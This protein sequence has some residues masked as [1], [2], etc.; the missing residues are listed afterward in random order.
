MTETSPAGAPPTPGRSPQAEAVSDFGIDTTSR[1]TTEAVGDYLAKVRG[2]E[3]GSLP[4]L[5]GL[6]VLLILFSVASDSFLTLGNIANLLAQGAGV[7]II[8]MGLV[9]VLLLGEIDLSAGTASGVTA[10][11]LALHLVTGGNLLGKLGIGVFALFC[12]LLLVAIGIAVQ[13]KIWYAVAPPAIALLIVL[14]GFGLYRALI[15]AAALGEAWA[16]NSLGVTSTPLAVLAWII[17]VTVGL[18]VIVGSVFLM[19]AVTALV[20]SFFADDIALEVER[21]H[22]PNEPVG[23]ALA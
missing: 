21:S 19:P 6:V 12:L 5:F 23:T 16:Q 10:A 18:G 8:A 22:Y 1:S 3:L 20:A 2:G 11:V 13:L 7:T 9:F 15:W 17:S 4:A 14:I